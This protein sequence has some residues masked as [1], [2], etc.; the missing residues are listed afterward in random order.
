MNSQIREL[1]QKA[2]FCF[3]EDEEWGPGQ[4]YIDW[5]CDY[6][7]QFEIFCKLMV[8]QIAEKLENDGMVEVAMEI[9]QLFGY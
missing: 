9:K 6:D 2:G 5:S 4:D 3:W 8:D 7:D 1:A